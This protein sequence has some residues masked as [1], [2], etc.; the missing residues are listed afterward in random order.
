MMRKMLT[1]FLRILTMK[2][3]MFQKSDVE[4]LNLKLQVYYLISKYI[5]L[6]S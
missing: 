4:L 2:M 5:E 6:V 3:G 1:Y